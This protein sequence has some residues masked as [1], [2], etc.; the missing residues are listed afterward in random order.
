MPELACKIG[1]PVYVDNLVAG[2]NNLENAT[3]FY[4]E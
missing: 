1:S 4:K 3:Q 2:A